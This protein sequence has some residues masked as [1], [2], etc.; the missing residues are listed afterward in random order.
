MTKDQDTPGRRLF[1][2]AKMNLAPEP[3]ALAYRLQSVG[4]WVRVAWEAGEFRLTADMMLA[5][6]N[7]PE[8]ERG[9]RAEARAWLKDR[10][11]DGPRPS[12]ELIADAKTDADIST[13]TLR[14]AAKDLGLKMYPS[15]PGGPWQWEL[16]E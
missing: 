11:R 7:A 3:T 6:E 13:S 2:P 12:K 15:G 1:L 5:M 16:P 8:D 10:L 9:A 14:R 4:E